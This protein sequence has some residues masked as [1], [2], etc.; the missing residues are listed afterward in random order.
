[1]KEYK[2]ISAKSPWSYE[3][4]TKKLEKLMNE[5]ARDGWEVTAMTY[6]YTMSHQAFATL[7]RL[8]KEREY[9]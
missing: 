3:G 7:E 9:V 6:T 5:A 1:M 4:V 2:I 8:V